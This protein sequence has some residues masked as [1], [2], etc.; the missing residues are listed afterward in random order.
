MGALERNGQKTECHSISK[1]RCLSDLR[2]CAHHIDVNFLK[3]CRRHNI[4]I[5]ADYYNWMWRKML[6]YSEKEWKSVSE[7]KIP[8][9][10]ECNTSADHDGI[11]RELIDD[12]ESCPK[13]NE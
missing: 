4:L 5:E 11:R 3:K 9:L 2:E 6:D 7:N 8:G 10:T 1:F 13:K 12:M